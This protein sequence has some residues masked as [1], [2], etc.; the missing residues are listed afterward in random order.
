MNK[1]ISFA[2]VVVLLLLSANVIAF[3]TIES[4]E[5]KFRGF[6]KRTEYQIRVG[7]NPIETFSVVRIQRIF[8]RKLGPVQFL[9]T[10]TSGFSTYETGEGGNLSLSFAGL[11]ASVGYDVWGTT[12]RVEGI[13]AGFCENNIL[14]CSPM[15]NWGLQSLVDDGR[16]AYNM[17]QAEHPGELPVV[18]GFSLG[19][20]GAMASISQYPNDYAGAFLIEGTLFDTN[21]ETIAANTEFCSAFSL[22]ID[23]GVFFDGTGL[24]GIKAIVDLAR[25]EPNNLSPIPGFSG[26]T[27][28]QAFVAAL[29]TPM[30]TPST[31]RPDYFLLAGDVPSGTFKTTDEALFTRVVDTFPN[32]LT[33][34]NL[35]DLNC[36]LAGDDTF[37]SNLDAFTGMVYVVG[38]GFGFGPAM[39]ETVTLFENADVYIN[40]IPK[41]GHADHVFAQSN[42]SVLELPILIWLNEVL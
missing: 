30:I 10:L 15:E 7:P 23:S 20:I 16:F 32:Y 11:L 26:L 42:E 35:L 12:N 13:E 31:P 18:G 34:K 3:P 40:F 2:L 36:G 21:S 19:S 14:D 39:L 17:I 5:T 25:T 22:A 33:S 9:P 8:G 29:S 38:G 24:P 6:L 28:Q 37:V 41:F 27:N 1:L 4:S